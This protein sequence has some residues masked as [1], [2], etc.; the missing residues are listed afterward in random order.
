MTLRRT[1]RDHLAA[2]GEVTA[3]GLVAAGYSADAVGSALWHLQSIGLLTRCAR[4]VYRLA[5]DAL[6]L[7]TVAS[8]LAAV[9]VALAR[10]EARIQALIE[11]SE[12]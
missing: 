7:P 9:A 5:P 4:G 10:C 8:P 3:A 11:R 6:L 2:R 1:I 12:G